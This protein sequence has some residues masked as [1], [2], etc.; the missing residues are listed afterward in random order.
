VRTEWDHWEDVD[1]DD[2]FVWPWKFFSPEEMACQ[3]TGRLVI[4][5]EF[6]QRLA[7]TRSVYGKGIRVSRGY[8]TPEHN[9]KVSKTGRDGPH[10][11]ARAI[12][13]FVFGGDYIL[14]RRIAEAHMFTGFGAHQKGPH[15]LRFLHLDDLPDGPGCPRPWGWTY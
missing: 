14:L 4:V 12:D 15:H 11:T 8:S 5:P 1:R 13:I 3:G 9:D 6:M 7:G 10:T 2:P